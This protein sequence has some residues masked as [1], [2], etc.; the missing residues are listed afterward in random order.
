MPLVVLAGKTTQIEALTHEMS[1]K[2]REV[3][4]QCVFSL[5]D[6]PQEGKVGS[7][8][9]SCLHLGVFW[10]VGGQRHLSGNQVS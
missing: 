3:Y 7:Q 1:V 4:Y 2:Q 5:P 8:P 10:Q 6:Q 9:Q